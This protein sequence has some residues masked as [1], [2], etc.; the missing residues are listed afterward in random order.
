VKA[1]SKFFSVAP[2]LINGVVGIKSYAFDYSLQGTGCYI[3]NFLTELD[4]NA[5]RLTLSLGTTFKVRSVAFEKL[6]SSGFASIYNS[7]V[8]NQIYFSLMFQELTK[9]INIFRAKITLENGEV[10][11]SGNGSVYY[12]ERGNY[13]VF[14]VPVKRGNNIEIFTTVPDEEVLQLFDIL[15]RTVLEKQLIYPHE[16]INTSSLQGGQYFYR[17]SKQGLKVASDKILIL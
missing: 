14:P 4:S 5:A 13:L 8:N 15:G 12:V 6:T 9:G 7:P 17:I 10:I 2:I 16:Y 3:T 1:S 11:Y